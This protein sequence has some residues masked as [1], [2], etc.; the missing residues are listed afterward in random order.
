MFAQP[1]QNAMNGMFAKPAQNA[2]SYNQPAPTPMGVTAKAPAAAVST[3]PKTLPTSQQNPVSSSSSMGSYKGVPITPGTDAQ[4]AAQI[5]KINAGPSSTPSS[6]QTQTYTKP[7]P[8][9]TVSAPQAAPPPTYSGLLSQAANQAGSLNTQAR[10]INATADQIGS[11]TQQ[12]PAELA[13]LQE[14]ARLEAARS[15]ADYNIGTHGWS[16]AFQQG[17]EGAV[18]RNVNNQ[19]AAANS[20][21]QLYAAQRGVATQA[22]T[23]QANA[24]NAA[25]GLLGTAAGVYQ[26]AANSA[27]PE[28]TGYGQTSFDPTTST[29]G[30]GGGSNLDPQTQATS[31]AQKVMS[32]QMTYDQA[33]SSMGYAGSAGTTFLNNA[34]TAAGGNPLHLQASG[35]A[36]QGVIGT[37]TAQQ[38]A[39][40]SAHQQAQNL[41]SQLTDLITTFGLNPA[42]LNAVNL[43]LQKIA[44]N[45]SSSQYKILNNYLADIASRYS[46]VLT[47]PGGSSTDTTRATA[48]GML[49]GIASGRSILEVMNSLDEQ[50]KA[51][52]AGVSTT[53]T[54]QGGTV[55]GA[56]PWH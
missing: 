44:K 36:T 35:S 30:S 46:Q 33:I 43:G 10:K 11:Q 24:Q 32:G 6:Q 53:G 41:Q 7:T 54:G 8:Q 28:V 29:F 51:V 13:A 42:D 14:A 5:A 45:T 15:Q 37:Q 56:N 4:V 52:I 34:I 19:E 12:S 9:P 25:G 23:G 1:A 39:Y 38:A 22:Y 17:Q 55:S 21:A 47:P 16:A 2:L 49:D 48:S 27:K 18:N 40:E 26:N 20:V 3:P 50:A 31:L